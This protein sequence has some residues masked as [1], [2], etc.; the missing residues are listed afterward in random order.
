M[1]PVLLAVGLVILI[2]AGLMVAAAAGLA[3]IVGATIL[4]GDLFDPRIPTMLSRLA[5]DRIDNFL[6]LAIPFFILAGRLMNT[7]GITERLFSFVAL[8][9]QP[10]RGGLGHANVLASFIFAGMSGSATADVVGLGAVEMRAMKQNGYPVP[11]SAGVTAASSLL[12]PILPPSIVLVAYAVQAEQ[13]VATLFLATIGPGI[14]IALCYMAWVAYVAARSGLPRGSVPR[15]GEVARAGVRALLPL[16]TPGII[17]AGIYTGVATPTEA[18]AIAVLYAFVLT[19][20]IYRELT[21]RQFL[22]QI[23]GTALDTATLMFIIALTSAFGVVMLRLD[24]PQALAA[25]V[26]GISENPTVVMFL[27]LVIWTVVGCFMAQTPA[28]IILTPMLLPI[29]ERV[30]IDPVH[31]GVVMALAL[32]IGLLTPPVGMVLYALNKI[33]FVPLAVLFRVA[34][35]YVAIA[36]GAT[37]LLILFPELVLALPH[38]FGLR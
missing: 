28:I 36:F 21:W 9:V 18:A 35:P 32:T 12:G 27:F 31:F 13:S 2:M 34:L 8:L 14:L 29:A 22:E 7:G 10:V 33:A 24:L 30:G 38:A 11:F 26:I 23:R 20:F 5:I 37:C 25:L 15:A 16:L 6:L 1:I 3:A 17:L 19:K 4:F